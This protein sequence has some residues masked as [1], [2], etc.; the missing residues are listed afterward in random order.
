MPTSFCGALAD[1]HSK[2]EARALDR[3]VKELQARQRQ[4]VASGDVESFEAVSKEIDDLRADAVAQQPKAPAQPPREF[5]E[6][7]E[8]GNDWYTKDRAM[9]AAAD[10]IGEDL[11]S[12]IPERG[13]RAWL[14]A[15][16]MR[17]RQEFPHKFSNPARTAPT[18]VASAAVSAPRVSKGKTYHDLPAD[19][20]AACDR[21]IKQGLIKDRAT[22]VKHYQW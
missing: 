20:K 13:Y 7:V 4:A 10:A 8:S 1:H 21:F 16:G 19:A 17:I 15:V 14:D 18:P 11:K 2:V 6:W 22:Y 9:N 5:T 12:M 3:A